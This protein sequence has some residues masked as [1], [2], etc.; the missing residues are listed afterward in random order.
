MKKIQQIIISSLAAILL[1]LPFTAQGDGMVVSPPNYYV[2]ETEQNAVLFYEDSSETE[3]LA[4]SIAYEGTAEEFAWLIPTPNKPAVKRGSQNLFSNLEAL[5]NSYNYSYKDSSTGLGL[6]DAT[7]QPESSV[8]VV[9]EQQVEY[10]D[11]TVLTATDAQDLAEWFNE[12]GFQYPKQYTYLL[13]DYIDNGWYFTALKL[14]QTVVDSYSVT[15]QL[16]SGQATPV[17]LTFAAENMVYPM[18]ISSI[19]EDPS[20]FAADPAPIDSITS[21]TTDTAEETTS[22]EEVETGT[23]E[24]AIANPVPAKVAIVAED[25]D[26][27]YIG[28][29]DYDFYNYDYQTVNLYVIDNHKVEPSYSGFSNA[30]SN[31][32]SKAEIESWALDTNGN[33]WIEPVADQYYLTKMTTTLY[34][35]DMTDDVFFKQAADDETDTYHS[36][37]DW[38]I[39]NYAEFF[40]IAVLVA[41]ITL[42]GI[43]L[44]PFG[45]IHIIASIIRGKAKRKGWKISAHIVQW[46]NLVAY[47]LM[48]SLIWVLMWNDTIAEL[49]KMFDDYL[50]AE[51]AGVIVGLAFA[52]TTALLVVWFSIVLQGIIMLVRKRR[53]DRKSVPQKVKFASKKK[54]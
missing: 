37:Y 23:A 32:V 34:D 14:N 30:Y 45:I 28:D 7:A 13:S 42:L 24:E 4:I 29:Y 5:T 1:L 26:Y 9:S 36:W 41:V 44:S 8:S 18:R 39:D 35:Y 12:N 53:R 50:Y 19:V 38:D 43:L 54:S 2:Y 20:I 47:L 3:T 33:P 40:G 27:D 52:C 22:T 46:L 16:N 15:S 6:G 48:A 31:W 17:V 10:Y 51:D 11:V 49:P 21:Y 25:F